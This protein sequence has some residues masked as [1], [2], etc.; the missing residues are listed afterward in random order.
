[1]YVYTNEAEASEINF[2]DVKALNDACAEYRTRIR[3]T[4][5]LYRAFGLQALGLNKRLRSQWKEYRA[6]NA[7][8]HEMTALYMAQLNKNKFVISSNP[9]QKRGRVAA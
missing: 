5:R 2:L 3:E 8:C 7:E 4:I 9:T 1:M 6:L